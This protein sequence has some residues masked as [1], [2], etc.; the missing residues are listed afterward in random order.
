MSKLKTTLDDVMKQ[1]VALVDGKVVN[2][3]IASCTDLNEIEVKALLLVLS[4]EGTQFFCK[5][6]LRFHCH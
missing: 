1:I 6:G 3:N 4:Y 2:G 5:F